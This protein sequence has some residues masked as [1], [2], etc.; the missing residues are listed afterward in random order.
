[1]VFPAGGAFFPWG[2][3]LRVETI[4]IEEPEKESVR[5]HIQ[6]TPFSRIVRFN[7]YTIPH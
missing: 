2:D 6:G 7:I 4:D 5:N 1:M 3:D